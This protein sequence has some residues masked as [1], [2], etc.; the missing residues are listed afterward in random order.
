MSG[1]QLRGALLLSLGALLLGGALLE[2]ACRWWLPGG[3]LS[4]IAADPVLGYR[5]AANAAF[6]E[7]GE[8]PRPVTVTTNAAGWRGPDRPLAKPA[9]TL[10]V[11]LVGDSYVEATAVEEDRTFGVLAGQALTRA[12][13]RP[14][15]VANFGVSGYSPVH[16]LLALR[17]SVLA[18][19]PDVVALFFFPLNDLEAL[20]ADTS[21]TALAPFVGQGPDGSLA[22]DLSFAD[23]TAFAA[24]RA[25][26]F[27]RRHFA[28]FNVLYER[29]QRLRLARYGQSYHAD[30]ALPPYLSVC[31]AKP[32]PRFARNLKLLALVLQEADRLCREAGAKLLVVDVDYD[33]NSPKDA[34][35]L[36]ALDPTLDPF[37]LEDWVGRW[38]GSRQVAFLG[39]QR[40]FYALTERTGQ[41]YHW[42]HWNYQGQ[43]EVAQALTEAVL[44]LLPPAAAAQ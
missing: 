33:G 18:T 24:K 3:G 9:G 4:S 27:L 12:A 40:R 15:E 5:R 32:D 29:L 13:G 42:T 39:L 38:A 44:P 34:A 6:V 31:T 8:N 1:K 17:D 23:T 7:T 36:K 19:R 26:L 2:G 22:L 35:R 20:T 21:P 41:S 28:V 11:A 10:R 37:C 25:G 43:Q 16:Y 30:A 14:V